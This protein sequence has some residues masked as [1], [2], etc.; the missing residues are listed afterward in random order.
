MD[1]HRLRFTGLTGPVDLAH[2]SV[3]ECVVD[4]AAL[5]SLDLTGATLIDVAF[6]DL[7]ATSV[8][9]RDASLRRVRIVGGRIGTLDLAGAQVAELELRDV[10]IDYLSLAGARGQDILVRGCAIRSLDLPQATLTR[11]SF[12]DSRT[13]ELDPRGLRAVDVD[14]R[15]LDADAFLDVASLRGTTLG[16]LQVERL[17]PA[18]AAA[19][20]IDVRD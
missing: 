17:A 11:V 7:R 14:L 1:A 8:S 6:S 5:E 3:E 13:G 16:P 4:D 9:A 2:A 20:G 19:A 18:F 15:G 12:E 10:R